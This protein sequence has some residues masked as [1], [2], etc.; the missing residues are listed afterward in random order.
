M[1]GID[2]LWPMMGAASLTLGL[3]HMM[4]WLRQ[5]TQPAHL[6]FSIAAAAVAVLSLCEL[7]IMSAATPARY[8]EVLRWSHVPVAVLAVSLVIFVQLHFRLGWS[9]LGFAA[10]A[11]RVGAL[12]PNFM[13]GANLNFQRIDALQRLQ[14][15]GH[16]GIAVPI[17]VANPWMLLA[18]VSNLLLLLF[19]LHAIVKVSRRGDAD[20][21]R[22]AIRVCGSI[23]LFLLLTGAWTTAVVLGVVHGP[24]TVNVAF[25]AIV[26]VM[27]Y[28]LGSDVIRTAQLSQKLAQSEASL[29]NS[30]QNMQLAAQAAGLGLWTWDLDSNDFWF[31]DEGS[32]LLGFEPMKQVD[33]ESLLA[34]VHQDDRDAIRQA[35]EEAIQRSGEFACEFRL[36]NPLGGIRWIAAN[37]RV[38]YAP[39][40]R[41]RLLRGVILDITDR[42]QADER[43]RRVVDGAPI[44]M[45][46]I[47]GNGRIALSNRQAEN[48]FG[49]ARAEL[50][51]QCIDL[52]VPESSRVDHAGN[53]S[54]Y[55]REPQADEPHARAM[56]AGRDVFGQRKDGSEV[57]LEI[58]L[59]PIRISEDLFVLASITDI[60]DRLHSEQE[61]ALQ[62]DELAHLSRVAMLGEISGSLAHELNQPLTAILSNAQAALRFLDRDPA[63]LREVRDSLVQ[64]VDSDKSASEVIRRLRMMLRKD[65]VD[66]Q[67]LAINEVVREVMRL[68][69]SDLLSRNVAV[70][71]DL[72]PDLPQV[73]GDRVQLQQVLL[74]LIINACDAM[75]DLGAGRRL[76]VGT[77]AVPGPAV[78]VSISDIGRGI[79]PHD[80]ER[81]FMP[82][83]TSKAEGIGLGLAICGT[84]VR[85]HRGKLWA[86]NNA[87]R[88]ATLRF[89]LPV[90]PHPTG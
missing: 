58:G 48:V 37:G 70:A 56:G 90:E 75:S 22:R 21:R 73:R 31:T 12:L 8:A 49:Y 61:A 16:E 65:K 79:P 80:L 26:L 4:V 66:Y 83:V 9:W 13:S 3:I 60:S 78:E 2:I 89:E 32:G 63:D 27:S 67:P 82:F 76:R 7:L 23:A 81:I 88:G 10:C 34:R 35:R 40:G 17:G 41:P 68:L 50:I 47:D 85:A 84:I 29:R 45:L 5:R 46:M 15:W 52:L 53:R 57:P 62:R 1:N 28:E 25:F 44:A 51:G 39:S 42:R 36:V 20:D 14:I 11:L 55:A 87:S 30:E 86:T 54:E 59:T 72:Q 24:L 77:R 18:Q 43:F 33:K 69:D 64:I 74:N 38:E 71:L 19:L 6:V